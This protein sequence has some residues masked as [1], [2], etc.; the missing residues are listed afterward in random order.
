M[1]GVILMLDIAIKEFRPIDIVV[2]VLAEG[3]VCYCALE[4]GTLMT[5]DY[6]W[7]SFLLFAVVVSASSKTGFILVLDAANYCLV[8]LVSLL[9]TACT[10][11]SSLGF[12]VF[13]VL[14]IANPNAICCT[15]AVTLILLIVLA[16][17]RN[18][19]RAK[20]HALKV[21]I[22]LGLLALLGTLS[23]LVIIHVAILFV[24]AAYRLGA[25]SR[26]RRYLLG[27]VLAFSAF[28]LTFTAVSLSASH[29]N[30]ALFLQDT[31]FDWR[32]KG[33]TVE[34]DVRRL[35]YYPYIVK[36]QLHSNNE[37]TGM[38]F[39]K[40]NYRRLLEVGEDVHNAFLTSLNDCGYI[41]AWTALIIC[42][43]WPVLRSGMMVRRL[44]PGLLLSPFYATAAFFPGPV[45]GNPYASV[46]MLFLAMHWR[47]LH[48]REEGP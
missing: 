4:T 18:S 47:V 32:I 33:G 2:C 11:A 40:R 16:T 28:S 12:H 46:A 24:L 21:I 23:R 14:Y 36:G 44:A 26:L 30:I 13:K 41:G 1:P 15:Q 45:Y 10:V 27:L 35:S 6:A 48:E 20:G 29:R 3:A 25:R 17:D 7:L 42:L 39:G 43:L 34:G 31:K 19:P 37:L 8:F 38:G 22:A 5:L 9:V